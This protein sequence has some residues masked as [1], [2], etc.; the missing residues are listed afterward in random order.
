MNK[1]NHQTVIPME[2]SPTQVYYQI[3]TSGGQSGSGIIWLK[4]VNQAY[5]MAVH[6]Y[7]EG[8]HT[9]GNYGTRI[10]AEKLTNLQK[11]IS[12]TY[13]LSLNADVPPSQQHPAENERGVRRMRTDRTINFENVDGIGYVE[14]S[15]TIT[16]H[17]GSKK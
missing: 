10:T 12:E 1:D 4:K 14:N 3:D 8:E 5:V 15:G 2:I 9:N 6:A 17:L 13:V 7:G 16:F 11:W